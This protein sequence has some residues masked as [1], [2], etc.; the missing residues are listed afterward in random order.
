MKKPMNRK[1]FVKTLGL[2]SGGL[3]IVS[4]NSELLDEVID[5]NADIDIDIEEAKQWFLHDYVNIDKSARNTFGGKTLTRKINWESFQLVSKQK[6]SFLWIPITNEKNEFPSIVVYTENTK[7]KLEMNKYYSQPILEGLIIQ[8]NGGI[9]STFKV[10]LAYDPISLSNNKFLIDKNTFTGTLIKC[11]WEDTTLTGIIYRNGKAIVGF[12][13]G[14]LNANAKINSECEEY[15]ITYEYGTVIDDSFALV[16]GKTYY[17]DCTG[18]LGSGGGAGWSSGFFD[19][20]A[21]ISSGGSG[22]ILSSD[23]SFFLPLNSIYEFKITN[24]VAANGMDR[25]KMNQNIEKI[26]TAT[27]LATSISSFSFDKAEAM[28]KVVGLEI[29]RYIDLRILNSTYKVGMFSASLGAIANIPATYN[30]A[31]GIFEDGYTADKDG[32]NLLYAAVGW[33][34]FFGAVAIGSPWIA[35]ATT[36]ITVGMFIYEEKYCENG[37]CSAIKWP[38]LP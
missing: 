16:Q 31:V 14:P 27:G 29:D 38:D 15:Y 9:F 23:P 33:G 19:P 10:Q 35:V 17:T 25:Y 37:D 20:F 1:T 30:L 34:G 32:W 18:I 6:S 22:P 26:V 13:T 8:K 11:D 36:A 28:A 3:F 4:C 12:G 5:P 7:W 24:A 21:I 2:F